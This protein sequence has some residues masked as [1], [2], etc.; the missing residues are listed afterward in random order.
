MSI[1]L[2]TTAYGSRVEILTEQGRAALTAAADEADPT[3]LGAAERLRREFPPELAAAALNQVALRRK[4]AGKFPRAD[5]MFLTSDGLQQATRPAVATWRARRFVDAGLGEVWDLGCG[6]GADAMA[7]QEAGV[8]ARGV[9]ADATTAAFATANL[10]LV[11]APPVV[12]ARAEEVQVPDGAAVFLD[13]ARRTDRGRTWDVADFTPPWS[14]VEH[15][16]SSEHF[17][18]V[19]LG[20]GLPKE[21]I[22]DGVAATWVSEKGSVA[23]VS[24]W[25]GLE[26]GD[27]AVV[28][29]GAG[30]QPLEV[31]ARGQA[32]E[33]EVRAVGSYLLEPDNAMIRAGLVSEATPG[34]DAWLLDPHL[35]YL[36]SDEPVH[37][38]L[39]DCFEVR[40]VLPYD[41]KTL[42]AHVKQ[43][44][45]GT[46]EIK[47]RGIDVDPAAL[48]RKLKPSGSGSATLL[49]S[50]TPKGA[51]VVVANR[52]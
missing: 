41:L 49:L 8:R 31:R 6:L 10:A 24:L 11:G 40:E 28:F 26:P 12:H 5:E 18:C 4:A 17:T 48:R 50:R 7:F 27:S 30:G 13:P 32:R 9:E 45:I 14:L 16:L 37:S 23:E 52:S 33:L 39:V 34:I 3:S 2:V 51:V 22:P 36:S 25:N 29:P 1:T 44:G 19:K 38:P 20:P 15:Y 47:C 46:L 43:Q 42:R 35:A 21:L